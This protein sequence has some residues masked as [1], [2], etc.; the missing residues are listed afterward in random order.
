MQLQSRTPLTPQHQK[1]LTGLTICA[2]PGDAPAYP[3]KRRKQQLDPQ[4]LGAML[5]RGILEHQLGLSVNLVLL[6]AFSYLLFPSLR[7]KMSAFFTLSYQMGDGRYGQGPRDLLLVLTFIVIFTGIRAFSLD[8]ALM[9]LA[10]AC[11]IAKKKGRVRFAEQSY[12]MVYYLLYWCWGVYLFVQD[13]PAEVDDTRSLL[14]SMWRDFPR[15][16]ID[17]G[18]KLYYLS[19]FAFWIQQI[20]VIHIED[21]RK[22][23]YQML[24]H[25]IITVCLLSGSYPYHQCRVGNAILVC[26]DLVDFIFPLAK[27]LRYLSLQTACDTAFGVFVLAWVVSRH[28]FYMAICWSIYAHVDTFTMPQGTYST[29]TG[30]R[31]SSDGGDKVLD[32]LFQPFLNPSATTVSFNENIRWLFLGLLGALQAITIVWFVMIVRVVM[33]VLRGEGADDTRSD[34]EEEAEEDEIENDPLSPAQPSEH[35]LL[36]HDPSTV[37]KRFIEVESSSDDLAFSHTRSAFASSS[38]GSLK[39][40][41]KAK[42]ISSG[43]NLNGHKEILN[44]IGCLSEEQLAREREKRGGGGSA[45]KK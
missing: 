42:G 4:S 7:E 1:D 10:G 11:G 6:V 20:L 12:M 23:H 39:R 33:R 27:I 16:D 21:P 22:D 40:K 29:L 5:R 35:D 36:E 13:T 34:G 24:A 28:V 19:Q 37:V 30:E 14:I 43:L 26:M 44:R 3:P 17:A 2:S 32:N 9:P 41:S 38:A 45:G 31:I 18:M 25:H 8:Y 15:L